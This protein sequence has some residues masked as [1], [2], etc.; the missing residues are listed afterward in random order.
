MG[1][2]MEE[3][4][5]LRITDGN[6][7]SVLRSPERG[8]RGFGTLVGRSAPM[9]ALYETLATVGPSTASVLVVGESGTGKEL[10]ARML[11][12]LSERRA[13]RF[14]A[15]NCAAVPETLMESELFGHEK[16]AFTGAMEQKPGCFELA[17]G[18]TLFLDE[19]SAMPLASQVKLLRVLEERSFRRLRGVKEISVDVR[20]VAAMNEDPE[21]AVENQ[22]LRPDL[23]FRLNVF[24]LRLPPLRERAIDV[25][26]IAA[27]FVETLGAANDK[28]L[29]G[30]ESDAL[31]ALASYR[32]PGNVREL[33][34]VI[35][36]AVILEKGPRLSA[37]GL[38]LSLHSRGI[39]SRREAAP[40]PSNENGEPI[41]SIGMTI[42]EV[43]RRLIL[44]TL[45]ATHFNRTKA[46]ALLGVSS[47]TIYNK[48]KSWEIDVSTHLTNGLDGPGEPSPA[49]W[50]VSGQPAPSAG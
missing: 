14:V 10:V 5:K 41:A 39:A 20:I 45:E 47:K 22:R 11:H 31:E 8:L 42:D 16:G 17:H 9:L 15:L 6:G 2:E 32:W 4:G 23:L 24:T 19:L 7:T 25:P 30:I 3:H 43:T 18:G 46:A 28:P 40:V 12:D 21:K 33:R 38:A 50:T 27:H 29:L 49:R 35:E 1:G 48:L 36:R 44:R 37:S 34:N 26:L 13:R